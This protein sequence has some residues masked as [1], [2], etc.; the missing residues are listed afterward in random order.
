MG[1]QEFQLRIDS[2]NK[3]TLCDKVSFLKQQVKHW[4]EEWNSNNEWIGD[5]IAT[6]MIYVSIQFFTTLAEVLA[7]E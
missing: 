1:L 3:T 6:L 7:P 5:R 2:L 4:E